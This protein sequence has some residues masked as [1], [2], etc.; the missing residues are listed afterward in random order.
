MVVVKK[1]FPS[2][3]YGKYKVLKNGAVV[4]D[5]GARYSKKECSK[6]LDVDPMIINLVHAT[7]TFF[8]ESNVVKVKKGW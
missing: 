1:K 5:S 3:L 7:K 2:G 8:T 4:F 6:L